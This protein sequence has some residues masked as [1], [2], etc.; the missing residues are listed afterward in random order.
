MLKSAFSWLGPYTRCR[1][2]YGSIFIRLAVLLPLKSAKSGEILE[3]FGLIAVQ[4]HPRS[5]ILV[6]IES[7]N[8]NSY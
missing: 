3:N 6:P 2:Q 4:G 7:A 8:A 5:L 1:W